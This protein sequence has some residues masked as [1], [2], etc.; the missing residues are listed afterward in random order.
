M[1]ACLAPAADSPNSVLRRVALL[2]LGVYLV[3]L[4]GLNSA[5]ATGGP[6]G[7]LPLWRLPGAAGGEAGAGPVSLLPLL[8]GAAW[9]IY[10]WRSGALR[11]ISLGTPRLVLPLAGLWALA[12]SSVCDLQGCETGV[13]LRLVALLAHLTWVYLLILNE[14]PDMFWALVLILV[15][16]AGMAVAQFI[17]QGDLGLRLLGE[18]PLDPA[19]R[20]ISIVMRD[21]Q[22]WLRGYGLTV[23]PNTLARTLAPGILLLPILLGP[24]PS[25]FRQFAAGGTLVLAY[26]G[27]LAALSRWG[28]I[29][30]FF[31]VGIAALPALRQFRRSR[32]WAA[33]G[34][35]LGTLGGIA[36]VSVLFVATYGGTIV[37][38]VV[39]TDTPI[40]SRSIWERERD[41]QVSLDIWR[42]NPWRGVGYGHYL[43]TARTKDAW[44]EV[45][46]SV[47]LLLAAELGILGALLWLAL[48]LAP[49]IRRGA[50][51]RFAPYTG[52]WLS[53]WLLGLLDTKPLPLLDIRSA[54]LTGLIAGTMALTYRPDIK[55]MTG[56][57][58]KRP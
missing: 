37:G 41:N 12:L 49:A 9:L 36:I 27:M 50:L 3:L 17:T 39:E 7:W 53:Y 21:G 51:D 55:D 40:E 26:A 46:H 32:R 25:R 42:E 56:R 31:G 11:T 16:Q 6:L 29:C 8:S 2:I 33:S 10:R 30:L 24:R 5:A 13:M 54:L 57:R 28:F 19:S 35:F 58:P 52:L 14:R 18:L 20:E 47:P 44:A 1:S 23:H 38:R 45:V 48:L 15:L 22:R 34:L 43:E 4:L